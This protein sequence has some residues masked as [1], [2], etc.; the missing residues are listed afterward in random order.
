MEF[1][2]KLFHDPKTNPNNAQLVF[3]THETSILN[4]QVFRRDQVW[5]CEKN[6]QYATEL[7]SLSEFSPRKGR[8]NLE[9]GYL[10]G[11]YGGL[12][13]IGEFLLEV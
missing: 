8:D 4:Q 9:S 5:F 7:Y 1:L 6:S 12:P 10:S 13:F 3:T 11:R 2:V